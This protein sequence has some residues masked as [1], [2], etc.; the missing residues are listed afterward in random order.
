MINL[1]QNNTYPIAPFLR[2]GFRVFFMA[3][4]LAG[5]VLMLLWGVFFHISI[6]TS[7]INSAI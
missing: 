3:A 2:S 7:N 5:V 1:N 6:L 4:G